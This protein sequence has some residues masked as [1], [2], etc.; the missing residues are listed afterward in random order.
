MVLKL[1][2]LKSMTSDSYFPLRNLTKQ[3][4][5]ETLKRIVFLYVSVIGKLALLEFGNNCTGSLFLLGIAAFQ[6]LAGS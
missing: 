2:S 1:F 3:I 5:C 6:A 4:K